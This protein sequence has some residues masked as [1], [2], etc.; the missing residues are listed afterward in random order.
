MPL[1][2]ADAD[3]RRGECHGVLSPASVCWLAAW[4]LL[5]HRRYHHAAHLLAGTVGDVLPVAGVV[6]LGRSGGRKPM[7]DA[8]ACVDASMR[9]GRLQCAATSAPKIA[10]LSCRLPSSRAT[11]G[12]FARSKWEHSSGKFPTRQV[13][14]PG[15][16]RRCPGAVRALSERL[17]ADDR[18][19]AQASDRAWLSRRAGRSV[20]SPE[21]AGPAKSAPGSATIG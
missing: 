15:M 16:P 14:S 2:K 4:R 8:Q 11:S 19:E 13:R 20:R 10:A 21:P 7:I 1:A 12:W 3:C 5:L 18:V 6:V 17:R 9:P